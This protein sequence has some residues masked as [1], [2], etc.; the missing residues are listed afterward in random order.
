VK[1]LCDW[2]NRYRDGLLDPEPQRQFEAH[3]EVC[4]ECRTRSLLLNNLVRVIQNRPLPDMT[5]HP[6]QV[7]VCACQERWSWDFLF[8]SWLRPSTAWSGLALLAILVLFLWTSPFMQPAGAASE[9]E[10]LM[11]ESA[12]IGASGS[13]LTTLADDEFEL[14]L[15]T[16]GTAK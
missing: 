16:G 6:E 4:E 14:W 5:R 9:Y 15:G 13:V 10:M 1:K 11:N 8:I 2:F 3:M 7:A 12:S